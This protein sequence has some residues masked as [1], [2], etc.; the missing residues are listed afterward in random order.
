MSE[1]VSQTI[2]AA[3]VHRSAREGES[4]GAALNPFAGDGSS[5]RI[6]FDSHPQPMWVY[7]IATLKFLA[8]NDAAV[9]SYGFTRDELLAMTLQD[10][11][12]VE[13]LTTFSELVAQRPV[14]FTAAHAS[15]HRRK[16]GTRID[17][18]VAA[19]DIAFEGR[20]SRLVV[21]VEV[22]AHK[23]TEQAL[24]ESERRFREMLENVQLIALTL[25]QDGR[26]TFCN[27]YLV[28]LSGHAREDM[29]GRDWFALCTD[30]ERRDAMRAEFRAKI[31]SG[32]ISPHEDNEIVTLRGEL[33]L[34]SFSNTVL[35][36]VDGRIVGTASIGTDVTEQRRAEHKLLHDALH[37]ALT[38]LPNR[39]LFSERLD[40]AIGRAKR[41]EEYVFAVLYVDLDRFKVINE[42][43]GHRIG[44]Q[45][46]IE[47]GRIIRRCVQA[48]DTVA[49]LGGDEFTILLDDI[50]DPM[51]ATRTAN[52]IHDALTKAI[53]I[54]GSEVFT[55]ASIGIALSTTGYDHAE[56][57]LRDADNA[58]YRA[59]ARGKARNEV[60]DV[61]MHRRAVAQLE[62]ETDLRRAL[63]RK[64]L[65]LAFQ[66]IVSLK[67]GAIAG[68]EALARW[69]HPRR[70]PVSPAEFIPVAEETGLIL[71]IGRWVLEEA[72]S[73]M[74][75]WIDSTPAAADLSVSVNLSTK[76]LHQPDLV[77]QI[78]QALERSRLEPKRLKLEITES[79]LME[80]PETA[81]EMLRDLR[82]RGIQLAIDDFG[83]GYSSLSYLLPFPIDALKIDRAFVRG[84]GEGGEGGAEN[85][86][87]VRT[88]VTLARNLELDV[89]AEGV[90]TAAQRI[91]LEALGC[92]HAQGFL[93]SRPV[94]SAAAVRFMES[95][96]PPPPRKRPSETPRP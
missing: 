21:A 19:H 60:F 85:L 54:G 45:L 8:V 39:T 16:D 96:P 79:V 52:R 44:D 53:V 90:E 95:A 30:A 74:R 83:T 71:P 35:R 33:R 11:R 23:R 82:S 20:A 87:L 6:L 12:P 62:M 5:F 42:S 64:E 1:P 80:N 22:T 76:Q 9:S 75:R 14:G 70:G 59:K 15:R 55:T 61:S 36:D 89:V 26:I 73:E 38:G 68:F 50:G 32:L 86:E 37:D 46:L 57:V 69:N 40:G 88:I 66:P 65:S 2:L 18:E 28:A 41:R 78:Q 10:I 43:L 51:H 34:I 49:R 72:C 91:R 24:L 17:V 29:L 58:M 4:A 93:F 31:E 3:L 67:T 63:D 13:E 81:F 7:E 56:D 47:A 94:D 92:Q 25:D 48:D 27:D 77:D 84:M